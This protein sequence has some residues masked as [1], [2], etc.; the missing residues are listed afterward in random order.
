R[1]L[2]NWQLYAYKNSNYL[3]L[4]GTYTMFGRDCWWGKCTFCSWTTLN[5]GKNFKSMSPKRALDEIGHILDNYP[6]REIMDDSGTFPVGD[7]LREFCQGMIKRGYSKK[8][9]LSCNMRFNAD[10]NQKDYQLMGRAGFRFLLY[11]LESANQNT[12]D[13]LDKNLKLEQIE[14]VL[15]WAKKAGLNPHLTAMIG[16]PWESKVDAQKTLALAKSFFERGLAD[17]LQATIVTPYPG[18]PLF[19]EA[20]KKSWLKTLNWDEYDMS[21]PV[22]KTDMSDEE[23][24]SLV[25][26]LYQSV[27]TP[28]WLLRKAKEGLSDW[29]TFKYYLRMLLKFPSKLLDFKNN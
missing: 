16:Y 17:T 20:Q 10:L 5:P 28:R 24:Q 25:R 27:L 7:W 14:P 2:T 12:L 4:P 6:V 15:T 21:R 26:G 18:T 23:I 1:E 11:G 19:A 22:L 3:R 29:D 13:R 8:I 9:R